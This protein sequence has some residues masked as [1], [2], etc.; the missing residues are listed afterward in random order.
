MVL[1]AELAGRRV[2]VMHPLLSTRAHLERRKAGCFSHT[3]LVEESCPDTTSMR[4]SARHER[5]SL[6]FASE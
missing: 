5:I 3:R 4:G 1:K 6:E 2:A